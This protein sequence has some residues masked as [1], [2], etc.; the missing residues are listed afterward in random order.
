MGERSGANSGTMRIMCVAKFDTS[1]TPCLYIPCGPARCPC[2]ACALVA[3]TDYGAHQ[4]S[5]PPP[6]DPIRRHDGAGPHT[7]TAASESTGGRMGTHTR[8]RAR[9]HT[10][11]THHTRSCAHAHLKSAQP[12]GLFSMTVDA[13][14][15]AHADRPCDRRRATVGR[16]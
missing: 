1:S 4:S 7:S 5:S 12:D 13:V 15:M 9:T 11:H 8:T 16:Y 10:S 3:T 14:R 2:P 6:V